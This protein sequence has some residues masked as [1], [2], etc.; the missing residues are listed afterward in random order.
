MQPRQYQVL[1]KPADLRDHGVTLEQVKLAAR[2]SAVY[3]SAG[4]HD[5]PGFVH[6]CQNSDCFHA[7]A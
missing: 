3:A 4:F 5:P 6:S 1:V 2:Q 7:K